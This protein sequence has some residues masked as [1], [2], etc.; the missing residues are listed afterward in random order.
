MNAAIVVGVSA[1]LLGTLASI[2]LYDLLSQEISARLLRLPFPILGLAARRLTAGL[3]S[4]IYEEWSL[5][6]EEILK[7][8]KVG[9][10]TRLIRATHY[11]L[12]LWLTK[13]GT[14]MDRALVDIIPPSLQGFEDIRALPRDRRKEFGVVTER[15]HELLQR[16]VDAFDQDYAVRLLT[17]TASAC[18]AYIDDRDEQAAEELAE[19]ARPLAE[20]L[21]R[22][23]PAVLGVRRAYARALLQLGRSRRAEAL[24][25]ELSLD[26]VRVVGPDHP[27]TLQTRRLLGWALMDEGRLPEAEAE[28]R[29]LGVHATHLP[30]D[31]VPLRLHI[32]CMLSW[33]V[34]RQGRRHEAED[35]YNAVILLRS[36]QL[37]ADHPDTLDA[38]HS[39]GKMFVLSGD[40]ARACAVLR[41]LLADRKRVQGAH[42]PDTWETRKYLAVARAHTHSRRSALAPRKTLRELRRIARAQTRRHGPDHP[43]TRDTLQWLAKLTGPADNQ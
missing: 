29:A 26:E 25:R 36:R 17:A 41:P 22:N 9:P 4:D 2:T 20:S 40:G 1:A 14:E 27:G 43:N 30:D 18:E 38:K 11:A 13:A 12:S 10:I 8:G 16:P 31:A 33:T 21:D 42:H 37:G 32:Q 6:V 35:G 19:A 39:K 23:H 15:L 7:D 24:L 28:F 3:R 5:E 34:S